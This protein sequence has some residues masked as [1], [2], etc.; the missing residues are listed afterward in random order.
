MRSNHMKH[1]GTWVFTMS[2]FTEYFIR[3]NG[4]EGLAFKEWVFNSGMQFHS[5]DKWWGD[6]GKRISAHEGLDLCLYKD[7][8]DNIHRI[9][10]T[11]GVPAMYPGR[12]AGFMSD[13]LGESVILEHEFPMAPVYQFCTIYAH[14]NRCPD[15]YIGQKINEGDIIATVA[16]AGR[17]ISGIFPHLHISAARVTRGIS[18]ENLDWATMGRRPDV[19][20]LDPLTLIKTN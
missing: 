16:D 12:V 7:G 4:L 18:Y 15:L 20:L 5:L 19:F 2:R 17:P 8:Q 10:D 11:A 3:A 14:T 9:K 13:F 1:P 6:F